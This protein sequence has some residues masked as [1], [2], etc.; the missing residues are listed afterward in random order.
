[1]TSPAGNKTPKPHGG[2]SLVELLVVVAIM[3]M[4]AG[5]AAVSLRGLRSPA[6]ASAA[7]EVSSAM[8]TTRQM[9]VASGRKMLLV[10]PSDT[11]ATNIGAVPLRSY[12]IFEQLD[13]GFETRE[14]PAYTHPETANTPP[15][16]LAKTEWRRLPEG[17]FFCNFA[18]LSYSSMAGDPFTGGGFRVGQP[19]RR[20]N[21]LP[22]SAAN[23][24]EWQ[25]FMSTNTLRIASPNNPGTVLTTL[26]NVPFVGFFPDGR[27]FYT[28]SDF[29]EQGA[30]RLVQGFVQN[31][32]ALAV[33][34]TNNFYYIETDSRTGRIRVRN[35]D[36][37]HNR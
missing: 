3:G 28:R 32:D 20:Q 35:Q 8:K 12:A 6:L 15:H 4:L 31:Q 22:G 7:N 29:Y 36:S 24:T 10:F 9:A 5:V 17:I 13:P 37:Y 16:F 26:N 30:L 18:T 2:F 25:Y 19:T 1:M 23:G 11:S 21:I 33:T 14:P 34:D 27:A